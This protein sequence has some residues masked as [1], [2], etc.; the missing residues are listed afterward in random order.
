MFC[1]YGSKK[2]LES[3][4]ILNLNHCI[5]QKIHPETKWGHLNKN[6]KQNIIFNIR[7]VMQESYILGGAELKKLLKSISKVKISPRDLWE[8]NYEKQQSHTIN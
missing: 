8:K 3:E 7:N 4:T 5:N 2:F 1:D 6:T